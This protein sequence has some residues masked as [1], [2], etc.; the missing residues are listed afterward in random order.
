M[1][2]RYLFAS[3]VFLMGI[4]AA[5]APPSEPQ[6]AATKPVLQLRGDRFRGLT[7]EEMTPAQKSLTDRAL[8]ARGT[9][10]TFNILLRSPELSE[11]IRGTAGARA[12][13]ELSAKHS[14]LAI[15]VNAR[16]W[17]TQFEWLV[18]RQAPNQAGLS[19]EIT[20]AIAEGRR[21][22][23][24]AAGDLPVYDFRPELI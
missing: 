2:T 4:A 14:E 11:I 9:I 16:Y 20:T 10:G 6:P 7:Y 13:S 15:L 19:T 8:A 12:R 23:A 5:Q 22:A 1:S 18:H 24:L 17:T 3:I 21:P